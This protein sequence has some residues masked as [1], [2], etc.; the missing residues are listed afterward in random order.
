MTPEELLS[1]L[2]RAEKLKEN[3]RHCWITPDRKESV[4]DHTWR[5]TLMAM[6][7][8]GEPEFQDVDLD[9]VRRMCLIHDLG[10]AF[11]GDIPAFE[12]S[13]ADGDRELAIFMNWVNTFPSPQRE[14]WRALL[15]EME[16][17]KT[18][19]AR[20][21]KAL[22]KLEAVISHDESDIR[23]WLPNEYELQLTYGAENMKVSPYFGRLRKVV[24]AWTRRKIAEASE[25]KKATDEA[26]SE[27]SH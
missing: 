21:Y 24:D 11:T 6:L 17:L 2:G 9:K 27:T 8:D 3:T 12:K 4:A 14:E 13:D 1:I 18:P 15:M 5:M 20:V 16:E 22:D 19:E 25:E 26:A 7:L 10:E 23:S